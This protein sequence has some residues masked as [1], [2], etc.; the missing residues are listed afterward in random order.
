[1][2]TNKFLNGLIL[3]SIIHAFYYVILVKEIIQ[4]QPVGNITIP[5]T[6]VLK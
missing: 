3:I 5:K 2:N 4:L 1:M 6:A